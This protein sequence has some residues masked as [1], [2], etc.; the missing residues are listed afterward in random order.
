M[1]NSRFVL[2]QIHVRGTGA[3]D[4]TRYL[5]KSKLHEAREGKLARPLFTDLTDNLTS[6][7]ARKWL[8]ITG[9]MLQRE[10]VLHYILSFEDAREY[11][12]LGDNKDER[13]A[14][15]AHYVRRALASGLNEIGVTEMRWVAGL[16]LN[17]DNP[18]VHLLLNKNATLRETKDLIRI[19]K[20][21]APLIAH[22]KL[23]PDGT[24]A[25]SYGTIINSFAAQ[26][27]ARHR[28][29]ARCLQFESP[30]RSV[31]FIRELLT[32]DT[33]RTRQP[34]DAERLV[35]AWVVAEIEATRAPKNLRLNSRSDKDSA[36]EKSHHSQRDI[37]SPANLAALR[38]E[39]AR[40]DRAAVQQGQPLLAA[41][42][43]TDTLRSILT[44]PPRGLTTS[45]HEQN[46]RIDKVREHE[47]I[48]HLNHIEQ[49]NRAT[50]DRLAPTHNAPEKEH[51][52]VISPPG[53]SR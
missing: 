23:Q 13:Q 50:P 21:T 45:P 29:S 48:Y 26:V 44:N 20:L 9:G 27:D 2:K 22:H 38:T 34:M 15:I 8:S 17:T 28:D 49:P 16:H 6:G 1:G 37:A 52:L 46:P 24:R 39:I 41:F 12:L 53:R 36:A 42:I 40:L 43:E 19:P 31:K 33:L 7:E 35:G 3:S 18:H 4:L 14:E 5:A 11:K 47:S 51:S 25:F 30:L 10:D 32:P